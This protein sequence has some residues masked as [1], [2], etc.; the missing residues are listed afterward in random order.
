MDCQNL[1]EAG[2]LRYILNTHPGGARLICGHVH[3]NVVTEWGGVICQIA[4]G[5]SHAV[6][7]EQRVDATNTLKIEP[8]ERRRA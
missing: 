2:P 3:R 4:Q 1:W 6:T 7:L 8:V 5:T